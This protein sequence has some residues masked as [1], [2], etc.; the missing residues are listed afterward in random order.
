MAKEKNKYNANKTHKQSNHPQKAE[1]VSTKQNKPSSALKEEWKKSITWFPYALTF[2]L[3]L[4]FF[5]GV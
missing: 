1:A 5:T 3:I 2:S 4:L